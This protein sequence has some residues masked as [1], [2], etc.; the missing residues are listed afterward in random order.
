MRNRIIGKA[1]YEDLLQ[2]DV[3]YLNSYLEDPVVKG[4][5]MRMVEISDDTKTQTGRSCSVIVSSR[6]G[7]CR[8]CEIIH[9]VV[10]KVQILPKIC[11][12][13]TLKDFWPKGSRVF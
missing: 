2:N 13:S 10:L 9:G 6:S 8:A 11:P 12:K 4:D 7:L 3:A 5:I 1:K